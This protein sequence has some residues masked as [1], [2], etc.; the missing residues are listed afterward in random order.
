MNDWF[1]DAFICYEKII[2]RDFS[3]E[4]E[5]NTLMLCLEQIE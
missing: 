1:L 3:F 4:V 2:Q 5:E